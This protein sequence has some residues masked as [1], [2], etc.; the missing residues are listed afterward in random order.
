VFIVIDAKFVIVSEAEHPAADGRVGPA[1][2]LAF[3]AD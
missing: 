1:E 3:G 2:T